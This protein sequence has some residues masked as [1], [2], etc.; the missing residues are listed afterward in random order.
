MAAMLPGLQG[1]QPDSVSS[2]IRKYAEIFTFFRDY[3]F[4]LEILRS[5]G[6]SY[7]DSLC[8]GE[9]R[10][11]NDW[12]AMLIARAK[13]LAYRVE[14]GVMRLLLPLALCAAVTLPVAA[15]T[16]DLRVETHL[17]TFTFT[18]RDAQGNLMSGLSQND[19]T[20]YEDGVPQ[21][22]RFFS[23]ESN[24]PLS[25][26]L[27][28]DASESQDKF[29]HRHVHDLRMFLASVLGPQDQVFALCFGNHLRIA[30]DFTS[31]PS[32]VI[33]AIEQYNKHYADFPEIEPDDTRSGGSAVYDAVYAGVTQKL[34]GGEAR[35]K[36]LILFTDGEEN[37]SAHDEI[38]AISAAQN[39]DALLYAIRY[40]TIKHGKLSADNRHGIAALHHMAEQTGGAD[41]DALHTEL[42]QDFAQI[43]AE[44]R[45]LYSIGY[46][47]SNKR[48]DNTFRRVVIETQT[49]GLIVRAKSGY[50]AK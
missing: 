13:Y 41:F 31:N 16:P 17:V 5:D 33:D 28:V 2:P 44:L 45:S 3:G 27:I 21:Q 10:S 24:I 23:R 46:Y 7:A 40:T 12:C 49:P 34:A 47:S 32:G 19:F 22:I 48:H 25:L 37:A 11:M 42:S 29:I 43:G 39:G 14:K 9:S 50:Y 30:S 6:A 35:R 18:V 1:P 4:F 38:D 36:A 26:G 15:Q 20:V 8:R